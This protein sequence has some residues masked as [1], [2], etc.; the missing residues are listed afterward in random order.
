MEE[1]IFRLR[2]KYCIGCQ[3]NHPSQKRHSCL[4]NLNDRVLELEAEEQFNNCEACKNISKI[5]SCILKDDT[6]SS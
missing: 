3:Y 2:N 5:H 6:K 1:I 4:D